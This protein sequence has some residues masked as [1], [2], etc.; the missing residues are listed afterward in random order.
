MDQG[1]G[2][3]TAHTLL[4]K[5][6]VIGM[7]LA[8][9]L[10]V[11]LQTSQ[12]VSL[13]VARRQ[14][15]GN[16][17]RSKSVPT[18]LMVT[19]LNDYGRFFDSFEEIFHE[20]KDLPANYRLVC[21]CSKPEFEY[22]ALQ[23][24]NQGRLTFCEGSALAEDDLYKAGLQHVQAA[25]L[26]VDRF[27][28]EPEEEDRS[29]LLKLWSIKAQNPDIPLVVQVLDHAMQIRMQAFL[30]PRDQAIS[31]RRA[32]N[33][34][35]STGVHCPGACT[36]ISN[37]LT[38]VS[39]TTAASRIAATRSALREGRKPPRW[40]WE[41]IDGA[42][43][44]VYAVQ[45]PEECTNLSFCKF[46]TLVFSQSS[47][48][49]LGISPA[50]CARS[51][52][53]F[54]NP[55]EYKIKAGDL[56]LIMAKSSARAQEAVQKSLKYVSVLAGPNDKELPQSLKAEKP[57]KIPVISTLRGSFDEL[58]SL[59]MS[60]NNNDS[61][62][63]LPPTNGNAEG[64]SLLLCGDLDRMVRFL[65]SYNEF[66]KSDKSWAEF[67]LRVRYIYPDQPERSIF[68]KL[69]HWGAQWFKGSPTNG[70]DLINAG[71]LKGARLVVLSYASQDGLSPSTSDLPSVT[72]TDA[73]Q[74]AYVMEE[75]H[76]THRRYGEPPYI[77]ELDF[78][79]SEKFL[80]PQVLPHKADELFD[81]PS[82]CI[83]WEA[84]GE[85]LRNTGTGTNHGKLLQRLCNP[86]YA[87]GHIYVPAVL[88]RIAISALNPGTPAAVGIINEV[89]EEMTKFNK[90]QVWEM[91]EELV[92]RTYGSL[93]LKFMAEGLVPLGLYRDRG[94][95]GSQLH[96]VC[97]NPAPNTLLAASDKIYLIFPDRT[98]EEG[99][100]APIELD[101]SNRN[102]TTPL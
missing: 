11:P 1:Y 26:M 65:R 89:F 63:P 23:E 73:I 100:F 33:R 18:L 60:P 87:A 74:I 35:L 72:D 14:K 86:F 16:V 76:R 2:D 40:I 4:G 17:P 25:L 102:T 58:F 7:L 46:S 49:L 79:D 62:Q 29:M 22:R 85:P 10:L 88:D 80:Q 42:S 99:A 54:L 13:L 101:A 50:K 52:K 90:I 34:L 9:L 83:N 94:R 39:G 6:T 82:T 98:L 71:V 77:V 53:V 55:K 3:I 27:P 75:I 95:K 64:E 41:Y 59:A 48:V 68:E 84:L 21:L 69:S 19:Q 24:L 30:G 8:A 37:L 96:Y 67:P 47:A 97:A 43:H 81:D 78:T 56:L 45:A 57:P 44:E 32:K 92:G 28:Q 36:L 91:P 70:N 20:T 66:W 61:A 12:L 93:F 15:L 31:L 51:R 5:L 38:G